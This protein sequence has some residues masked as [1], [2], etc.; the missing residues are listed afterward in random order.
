[1]MK[2]KILTIIAVIL[3]FVAGGELTYLL[4]HNN[5][6]NDVVSNN[7]TPVVY[8]SCSNYDKSACNRGCNKNNCCYG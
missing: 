7:D 8:N 3:A 1:M 5:K 6:S 4:V 2:N